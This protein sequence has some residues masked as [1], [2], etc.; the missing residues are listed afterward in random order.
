MEIEF[1]PFRYDQPRTNSFFE[2]YILEVSD[3]CFR[4]QVPESLLP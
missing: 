1:G 4:I 2:P 3:L